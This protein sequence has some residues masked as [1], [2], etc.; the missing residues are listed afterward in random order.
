MVEIHVPMLRHAMA[1]PLPTRPPQSSNI[2][3]FLYEKLQMLLRSDCARPISQML[4]KWP[5]VC[6]T[7]TTFRSRVS[8]KGLLDFRVPTVCDEMLKTW[9]HLW[10]IHTTRACSWIE[11]SFYP[12]NKPHNII[13]IHN[14]V[15]WGWQYYA[16]YSWTFL[17]FNVWLGFM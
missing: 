17:T 3:L 5:I 9:E 2:S 11:Y 15:L 1:W 12:S 10:Q 16:E 14:N 4:C 6:N 8:T 13:P 7:P